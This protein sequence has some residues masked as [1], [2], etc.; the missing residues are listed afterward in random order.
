M[1]APKKRTTIPSYKKIMAA[2]GVPELKTYS[3]GGT[4]GIIGGWKP[5]K[6]YDE[7]NKTL[8]DLPAWTQTAP[9]TVRP[10]KAVMY[11]KGKKVM[12]CPGGTGDNYSVPSTMTVEQQ[13]YKI[14]HDAPADKASTEKWELFDNPKMSTN[15]A[16]YACDPYMYQGRK[17]YKIRKK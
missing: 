16:D 11:R 4:G 1:A 7:V 6:Y 13:M 5:S 2:A 3:A 8:K 15:P 14:T 9:H 17:E 10:R 12:Q